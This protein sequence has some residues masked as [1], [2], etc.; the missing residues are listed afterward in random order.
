MHSSSEDS[1]SENE[2]EEAPYRRKK[3]IK[4]RIPWR[5]KEVDRL[6]DYCDDIHWSQLKKKRP[7]AFAQRRP[8]DAAT[9]SSKRKIPSLAAAVLPD[10]A[11]QSPYQQH[12]IAHAPSQSNTV[13]ISPSSMQSSN[14]SDDNSHSLSL[15]FSS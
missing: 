11:F 13:P 15:T 12:E 1:C 9:L 6:F 3:F 5:S 14:D 8:R 10:W 7:S 2:T 4:N